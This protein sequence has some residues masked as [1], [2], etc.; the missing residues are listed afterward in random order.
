MEHLVDSNAA[1]REAFEEAGVDG[2]IKRK[3]SGS[4]DYNK[5]NSAGDVAVRVSVYALEV[6]REL[7]KWPEKR[8]RKRRWFERDAAAWEVDEPGLKELIRGFDP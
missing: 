6:V 5:T 8:E 2:H 3:S 1:K 4:F 7:P